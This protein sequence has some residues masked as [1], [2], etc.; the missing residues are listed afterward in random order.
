ML[1]GGFLFLATKDPCVCLSPRQ[2]CCKNLPVTFAEEFH[3]WCLNLTNAYRVILV[4][5]CLFYV[6][7]SGDFGQFLSFNDYVDVAWVSKP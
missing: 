1:K 6:R 5:Y 2:H 7:T 4:F 3:S